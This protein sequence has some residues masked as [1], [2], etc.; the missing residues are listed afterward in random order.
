MRRVGAVVS[1]DVII[2][3]AVVH[4]VGEEDA[5]AG[6]AEVVIGHSVFVRAEHEQRC[7]VTGV[8]E[9]AVYVRAV[10]VVN[11]TIVRVPH[12]YAIAGIP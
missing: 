9:R 5:V 4:V 10:V 12:P 7:A 11:D 6:I 3:G 2:A 1:G 8:G